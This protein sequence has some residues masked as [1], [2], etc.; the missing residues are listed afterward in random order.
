MADLAGDTARAEHHFR[1]AD[2]IEHSDEP[3]GD[4][5]YSLRGV[6]WAGFLARTGRVGPARRLTTANLAISERNGWG[7]DVARCRVVLARLDLADHALDTADTHLQAALPTFRDGDY[8]VELAEALTVAADH[9]RRTGEHDRAADHLDEAL[10]LA[11]PRGLTPTQADAL[12]VRAHLSADQ[13][14]TTGD[15]R[16]LHEGR[17]AADAALRLATGPNPLPWQHLAALQAHAHLDQA[18]HTDHDWAHHAEQ[19][20]RRLIPTRLDPDPLTTIE[21]QVKREAGPRR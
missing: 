19:L 20:R 3:D 17:D 16:H 7:A 12:T 6:Q 9:A 4:H 13:H 5:L 14:T 18:A 21:N 2:H 15:P 8:L 11:G 1:G 10:T